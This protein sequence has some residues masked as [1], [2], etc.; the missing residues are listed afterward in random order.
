MAE[1]TLKELAEQIKDLALELSALTKRVDE[2]P[3]A[4]PGAAEVTLKELAEQIK[5]L[6]LELSALTKR[7]DESPAAGPGT[8]AAPAHVLHPANFGIKEQKE[9]IK[10]L[11]AAVAAGGEAGEKAAA[12]L[13]MY[14]YSV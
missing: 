2:S 8:R 7:V 11:K 13:K 1:V 3:A 12:L 6:A 10:K 4:G 14:G 5:N 9:E